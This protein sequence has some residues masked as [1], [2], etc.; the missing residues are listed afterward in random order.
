MLFIVVF[1]YQAL[2]YILCNFATKSFG[3]H[4]QHL[5]LISFLICTDISKIL[6]LKALKLFTFYGI[7]IKENY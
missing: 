2:K 4:Y 1:W 5:P 3:T 7:T 6:G